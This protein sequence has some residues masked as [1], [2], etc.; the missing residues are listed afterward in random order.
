[1]NDLQRDAI[2]NIPVLSD[3]VIPGSL[4]DAH[5]SEP[6]PTLTAQD[7]PLAERLKTQADILLADMQERIERMV[8]EELARAHSTALESARLAL[9]QRLRTEMEERLNAFIE[10]ALLPRDS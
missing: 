8:E 10:A 4:R 9:Q 3:V 5:E 2:D 1:M 6:A 7:H